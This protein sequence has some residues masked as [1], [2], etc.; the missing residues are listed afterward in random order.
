MSDRDGI[1]RWAV[2][3]ALLDDALAQ[4]LDN[5]V[6]RILVVIAVALVGLTF[7]VGF[8]EEEV[9]VLFGF[10][11]YQYEDFLE[12][13]PIL[14]AFSSG[15]DESQRIVAISGLQGVFVDFLAGTFGILFCVAATAFFVPRML[16]K[17]MADTLFS[18]PVSRWSLLWARYA[19][20]ILFVALLALVLIG[21][22][23]L[24]LLFVSG[25]S[26][27]SY[28]WAAP[29]LVYKFAL[30]SSYTILFGV[31]LRNA[32]ATLLMTLI[33]FGFT[34]GIHELWKVVEWGTQRAE[35]ELLRH[36]APVTEESREFDAFARTLGLGLDGLHFTLPKLNDAGQVTRLLREQLGAA[37]RQE[38][39]LFEHGD[40]LALVERRP[41]EIRL[42]VPGRGREYT[43]QDVDT[44]EVRAQG[45]QIR[46]DWPR[47]GTPQVQVEGTPVELLQPSRT[48]AAAYSEYSSWYSAAFRWDAPWTTNA[49]FSIG[50][51]LAF[52]AAALGLGWL[53][54]RR[55]SF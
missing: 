48:S 47:D 31:V 36:G 46:I 27:P 21:G 38:A 45:K 43:F 29:M 25:Y 52:V 10:R 40:G 22:T 24:G 23:H 3:R 19:S 2:R 49:W 13:L 15:V 9:V 54:L 4:V 55:I 6:F 5:R 20:S 34:A 51:S 16:E 17:G 32:T 8:R 44:A 1:S 39:R 11:R 28:L 35:F 7:A 42:L 37:E 53:R 12:Y 50:S 14:Q 33:A 41:G 26:D 18:K 30:V